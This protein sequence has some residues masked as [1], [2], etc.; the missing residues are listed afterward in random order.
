MHNNTFCVI[1]S[2]FCDHFTDVCILHLWWYMIILA[3]YMAKYNSYPDIHCVIVITWT[4][5]GWPIYLQFFVYVQNMQPSWALMASLGIRACRPRPRAQHSQPGG[6]RGVYL[7]VD[8]ALTFDLWPSLLNS[9]TTWGRQHTLLHLSNEGEDSKNSK[10]DM[11]RTMVL[12]CLQWL[13]CMRKSTCVRALRM[14][15][16]LLPWSSHMGAFWIPAINY[17]QLC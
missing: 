8:S 4:Q 15:S 2:I 13:L 14:H 17:I 6:P 16:S 9:L 5:G 7:S 10:K 12:S 1:W 3:V 11:S